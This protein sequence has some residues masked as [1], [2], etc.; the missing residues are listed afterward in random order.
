MKS[1]RINCEDDSKTCDLFVKR[2]KCTRNKEE[3]IKKC[4]KSCGYCPVNLQEIINE[5]SKK[6]I[7]SIEQDFFEINE[8][9]IQRDE[10][11]IFVDIYNNKS[12]NRKKFF[13][14]I[15]ESSE[16]R[17]DIFKIEGKINNLEEQI[18]KDN[19]PTQ[20]NIQIETEIKDSWEDNIKGILLDKKKNNKYNTTIPNLK[21]SE[22]KKLT[23]YQMVNIIKD[24]SNRKSDKSK[25]NKMPTKVPTKVVIK[26]SNEHFKNYAKVDYSVKENNQFLSD[27]NILILFL[28]IFIYFLIF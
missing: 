27:K 9:A 25:I 23:Y 4:K 17:S 26:N 10:N 1:E 16:E 3:A 18:L 21:K 8:Q 24:F 11:L 5:K 19:Q 6:R 13:N 2:G 12:L 28:L 14:N 15:S 7:N 22:E 20:N